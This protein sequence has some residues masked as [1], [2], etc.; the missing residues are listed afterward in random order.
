[1]RALLSTRPDN[2]KLLIFFLSFRIFF[3]YFASC[4]FFCARVVC[5]AAD[6]EVQSFFF[7]FLGGEKKGGG[8]V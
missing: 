6:Y 2:A 3:S 5:A 4:H 7:F 8:R 1:M